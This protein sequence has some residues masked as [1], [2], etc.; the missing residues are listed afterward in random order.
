MA[1]TL[2]SHPSSF[3]ARPDW[4]ESS[5]LGRKESEKCLHQGPQDPADPL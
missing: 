2:Q 4:R 3:Q 1:R 5:G